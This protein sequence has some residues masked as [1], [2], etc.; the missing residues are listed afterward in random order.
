MSSYPLVGVA[1]AITAIMAMVAMMT[2]AMAGRR[3]NKK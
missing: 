2:V 3:E 1:M